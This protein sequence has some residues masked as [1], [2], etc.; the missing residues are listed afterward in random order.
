MLLLV[1]IAFAL[2]ALITLPVWLTVL[3]W[4]GKLRSD[5]AA[6]LGLRRPVVS[7]GPRRA[8]V[9]RI[10]L[11]AVS[12]GEVQ[13]IA[14]LAE[15]LRRDAEVVVS[16]TTDT[17]IARARQRLGD[18]PVVRFPFDF[19][20][21]MRGLI[22]A[23]QP[24]AVVLAELELWPNC[25]ALCVRQGIRIGVVNGRLSPRSF[26]RYFRVRWLLRP[27]FRRLSFVA[28]QDRAY[29][30]R[31]V[32]MGV[33]PERVS[34]TGTM[35]WDSAA[36]GGVLGEDALATA[37]GIDRTK[38]LIVAGSTAPGEEAMLHA[39][40]P[41][42]VQLLCAPRK[43]EWFDQAASAMPGCVRR[44]DRR[45]GRH[46]VPPSGRFLL[47]TIGELRAAYSLADVAVIG[48]SFGRLHGSDMMEPAALGKAVVVGPRVGDFQSTADALLAGDVMVQVDAAEL[49][50]ALASL[51]ADPARRTQLAE[52]AR[53]VI[54]KEQGATDRN[55]ALIRAALPRHPAHA[56]GRP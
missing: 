42:G 17:G 28:A 33:A 26:R 8:G 46:D 15:R 48:R 1:D 12:V 19:S 9:P 7:L 10:L 16:V 49:P 22:R 31:F 56:G 53:A 30:E 43:P 47:D 2:F 54:A 25:T 35:K 36:S 55:A 37:L 40:C 5:W 20:W 44:S 45:S 39:A 34:V 52:N 18:I 13:A 41:L 50:R 3:W 14:P 27:M 51:L 23:V 38:P 21:A 6:R 4:K 29:A 32:A 11:H 24:D